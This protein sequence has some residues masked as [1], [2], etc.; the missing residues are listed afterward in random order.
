MVCCAGGPVHAV[1]SPAHGGGEGCC[2][3]VASA[4]GESPEISEGHADRACSKPRDRAA[5][6]E[7]AQK[8]Q[9]RLLST[10][11]CRTSGW[12]VAFFCGHRC[13][14]SGPTVTGCICTLN[15]RIL[16]NIITADYT[17]PAQRLMTADK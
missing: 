17:N 5:R 14:V 3:K 4:R 16:R 1:P 8:G 6:L 10:Q 15:I 13:V 11:V 12:S 9:S 2:L 7:P